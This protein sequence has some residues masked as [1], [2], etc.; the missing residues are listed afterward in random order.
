MSHFVVTDA[1]LDYTAVLA[2]FGSL[3]DA[4]VFAEEHTT[5]TTAPHV[6][7]VTIEE[8]RGAECVTTWRRNM[9]R[10]LQWIEE[11]V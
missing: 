8:W 7:T 5:D 4:R 1:D 9:G 2:V 3:H 10:P 11:P 6:W